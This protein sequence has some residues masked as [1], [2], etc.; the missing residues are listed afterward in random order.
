MPDATRKLLELLPGAL[1]DHVWEHFLRAK[2]E[3]WRE[4][5][6]QVHAWELDRYL[7]SY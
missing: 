2:E 6:A 1:G 7:G 3:V 5:S 4:Y